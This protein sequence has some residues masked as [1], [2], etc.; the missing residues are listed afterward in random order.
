MILIICPI[1]KVVHLLGP[2]QIRT[3]F[4]LLLFLAN[5]LCLPELHALQIDEKLTLRFL[6]VS[7]TKKTILINRGL[8]DG[9]TAGDH[10]KFFITTG[11]IA[12]GVVVKVSPG[13][14]I[15][16]I[17]R[18]VDPTQV[19]SNKVLN[20][21]ISSPVKVSGDPSKS[22]LPVKVQAGADTLNIPIEAGGELTESEALTGDEE[23]E[24]NSLKEQSDK[25]D[26]TIAGDFMGAGLFLEK[27]WEVYAM[28]NLSMLSS[29]VT[30][31]G[32]DNKTGSLS[33][34][35]FS[36]GMER[37]FNDKTSFLY[38]LSL[39]V[40]VRKYATEMLGITGVK[41]QTDLLEYGGGANWHFFAP[42]FSYHRMIGFLQGSFGIGSVSDGVGSSESIETISG[43]LSFYSL[44]FG[45]KYYW[46]NG[47]GIRG[48]MDYY[49]RADTIKNTSTALGGTDQDL[50][51]T[52]TGVRVMFGINY[53][54]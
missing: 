31:D 46:E 37:Y 28:G 18:L 39:F 32:A 35:D 25:E 43:S 29:T 33:N 5:T 54:W 19:Y 21:K 38:P 13:R 24:L 44:G 27:N 23:K 4:L 8:E 26:Q 14:S 52:S 17:Y 50:V 7:D 30:E 12:R 40:M 16:S 36:M 34:L 6:R 53:R 15:W 41:L 3:F 45:S 51:R 42:A 22:L 49:T 47:F 2:I 10:G 20:L 48:I 1:Q 11:V 9:L